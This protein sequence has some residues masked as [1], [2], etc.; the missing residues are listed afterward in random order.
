[1]LYE[2]LAV[3][4]INHLDEDATILSQLDNVATIN[5]CPHPK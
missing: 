3:L 4:H 5:K 1:M 2:T